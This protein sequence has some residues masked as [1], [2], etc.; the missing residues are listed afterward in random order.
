MSAIGGVWRRDGAPRAADT[1]SRIMAAQAVYGPHASNQRASEDVALGRRLYRLLPEDRFDSQPLIGDR[2]VIMV[3]D[4]RLDNRA[5]LSKG[6]S[7]GDD[8]AAR[9]C[10]AALLLAAWEKLGEDCF[11]RLAGVYAFAVWEPLKQRLVLARDPFGQRPLHYHR[12]HDGFAFA[13]MPVGL[14]AVAAAPAAPDAAYL[15]SF[16]AL[17]PE[18]GPRSFYRDIERVEPGTCL[19]VTATAATARRHWPPERRAMPAVRRRDVVDDARASLDAAVSAQLRAVSDPLGT[20][21]SSGWDSAAVTATAARLLAPQGK[22]IVAF[23]ATPGADDASSAPNGRHCD[24]GALAALLAARY[25]GIDHVLIPSQG[26]SPLDDV[27]IDAD[28]AGAPLLNPCNQVWL[29]DINRSARAMGVSVI[30][31]GD[32]GNMTLTYS[33]E[34]GLA[35]LAFQHRWWSWLRHAAA[36]ARRGSLRWRGVLA[37]S[38][39]RCGPAW[40][41]AALRRLNGQWI[42]PAGAYS[43]LRPDVWTATPHE[44][45]GRAPTGLARRVAALTRFDPGSYYKAVLARWGIDLR[46][47]L[48]DQRVADACLGAPW[49]AYVADGRPRSLARFVLADRVPGEILDSPTRGYQ[50]VDWPVGLTAARAELAAELDRLEHCPPAAALLDIPR[51]RRLTTQWPA[52]RFGSEAVRT[53]Y[54]LALL[55]GVTTGRFIRRMLGGNR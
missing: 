8:A 44:L 39:E 26:R 46:N 37:L 30:L 13:S 54:R 2:G 28:L 1:C 52:G 6:L 42:A 24:E 27:D 55:R 32:F 21:L 14:Q 5:E 41:W 50:A 53:E 11:G 43:P 49:E 9:L 48:A 35:D 31:T 23:T 19:T 51:L 3:A 10:D 33:G 16:L 17:T 29:N 45:P 34:D 18:R 22:R 15:A 47:P 20:H 7:L 25:D 12:S 40:L 38:F 4:V 36:L